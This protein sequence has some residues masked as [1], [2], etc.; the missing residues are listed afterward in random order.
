MLTKIWQRYIFKDLVKCFTFFLFAFFLLY[1]LA[2]FSTHTQDFMTEKGLSLFRISS[3][4]MHQFFKRI[5]LLF[6]LALL[7]STIKVLSSM[8]AN[9]EL[10]ALQACGVKLKKILIP[11]WILACFCSLTGYVNEEVIIP[12]IAIFLDEAKQT[13]RANVDPSKAKKRPFTTLYLKDSS[14]LVYQRFDE[15]K[16][17]FFDVYWI[18][19]FNDIWRMKYLSADPQ[20]PLAEFV[21]HIVRSDSGFLEKKESYEQCI[22]PSLKWKTSELYKKYTSAKH[23]KISNLAHSLI[24]KK[25]ESFHAKGEIST[26][27][28]YKLLTPL[29]PFLILLGVTPYCVSYS[30]NPSV[31]LLYGVSIFCFVVFFTLMDSLI[32]I[33][34]N[35]TLPPF[36]VMGTPFLLCMGGCYVK[37]RNLFTS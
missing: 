18:R 10:V 5:S 33:G 9:R 22:L 8:N 3:Y 4:Y 31:F 20:R 16:K 23:Q 7:I 1:F 2:D 35:Q 30:R 34:E 12:K 19:S 17:A 32:I 37:F 14:R 13:R 28:F 25:A 29:M 27:L 15:K 26:Y 36:V 11:F 6:P 21:D 24:H